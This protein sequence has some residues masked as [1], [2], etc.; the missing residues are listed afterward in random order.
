[1][2]TIGLIGG[3]GWVSTVEYYRQINEKVNK[4]KGGLTFAKCILY[5]VNYGELEAMSR[6]GDTTG[7][8]NLLSGA[9]HKLI[10]AGADGIALCANTTHRYADRLAD[11]TKVPLIHIAE[12]TA[13]EILT[14][15]LGKVGLLGT[16]PTMEE[17]FYRDKLADYGI[18][19]VVPGMDE[20]DYIHRIINT[21]LIMSIFKEETR[22]RFVDIMR[23]LEAEGA[24]AIVLGCTEIPLLIRQEHFHLP[25]LNTLDIH[26]NAITAFCIEQPAT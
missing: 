7:V 19:T 1:M 4:E 16:R 11:E 20:R 12:A 21:E 17:S 22:E 13:K 10:S 9:A 2:K 15:K 23:Q 6:Q 8:Y 25:V 18:G 3:T 26:T 24:Q 14:K 5:S